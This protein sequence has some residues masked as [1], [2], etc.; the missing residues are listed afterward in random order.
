[1]QRRSAGDSGLPQN[2]SYAPVPI[3]HK[4]LTSSKKGPRNA[5]FFF[6]NRPLI[7]LVRAAAFLDRA[8]LCFFGA[9]GHSAVPSGLHVGQWSMRDSS[10]IHL[11]RVGDRPLSFFISISAISL[12]FVDLLGILFPPRK[13]AI[14]ANHQSSRRTGVRK[15]CVLAPNA[16]IV[17]SL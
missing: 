5:F 11:G 6:L 1:M 15:N 7:F 3:S 10:Q 9:S 2:R 4:F 16:S 8:A 13:V 12:L 17:I 14:V